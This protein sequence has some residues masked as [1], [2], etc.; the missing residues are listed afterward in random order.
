MILD[1]D[2]D[3]VPD[4]HCNRRL[5]RHLSST[6]EHAGL[7]ILKRVNAIPARTSEERRAAL[8]YANNIRRERAELRERLK[9]GSLSLDELLSKQDSDV[10]GRW[11]VI[12]VLESLPG[13]GKIRAR[14]VMEKVGV[15]EGRRI[16]G[17]GDQQRARLLVE[18][19]RHRKD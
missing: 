15:S 8:V 2:I 11:R 10:V 9:A 19:S 6:C 5:G 17:L 16:K 13:L 3:R 18:V 1:H 12:S 4:F 14:Q 7:T